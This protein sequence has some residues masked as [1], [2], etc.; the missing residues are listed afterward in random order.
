VF[1]VLKGPKEGPEHGNPKGGI[2]ARV[3]IGGRRG[4][5]NKELQLKPILRGVEIPLRKK[6]GE[7]RPLC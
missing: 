1:N 5:S 4:K 7:F 6:R 2:N 3:K